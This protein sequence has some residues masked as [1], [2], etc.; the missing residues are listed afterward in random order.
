MSNE[1]EILNLI[2]DKRKSM[3]KGQKKIADYLLK[4]YDKAAFLT[5]MELGKKVNVSE[6]TVVRFA[7]CIGLSGYP[8]LQKKLQGM[9][10]D[11]IHSMDRI[12]I[13]NSNIPQ[14]KI[15]DT[16]CKADADK[17]IDT[18]KLIDRKAFC[19]AVNLLLRGKNIYIIGLRN[20]SPLASFLAYY[21]KLVRPG[22]I[23]IKSSNTNELL[24]ELLHISSQDVLLSISFPKYSF[25]TLKAMEYAND[26]NAT[27]ISVTDSKYSPMN[28]YSSCNLFARS[29]MASV[30]DS[31]VAPLSV[32][33][34]LIV[35]VCLK[36]QQ[37]LIS[38]LELLGGVLG[39]YQIGENDEIDML[40]ENVLE[41]L[42]K[43][44]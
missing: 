33:N 23:L 21:L 5:A 36:R 18:L 44:S 11:K 25:R 2:R 28:M 1:P 22:I 9:I 16:V 30:V 20:C 12:E 39:N 14:E 17:I 19:V 32:I 27:I 40:D 41:E 31:L 7:A 26:R 4:H 37:S 13:A 10:R 42:R 35:A 24:E 43:M 34:A 15:L 29:D 3:S 38:N 8:K 6:S